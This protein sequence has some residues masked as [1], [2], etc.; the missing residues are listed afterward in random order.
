[1]VA[2][3]CPSLLSAR[4]SP[5]ATKNLRLDCF[6]KLSFLFACTCK[7][8]ACRTLKAPLQ[9]LHVGVKT[10]VKGLTPFKCGFCK[11]LAAFLKAALPSVARTVSRFKNARK[12]GKTSSVDLLD[13][14]LQ[15]SQC[16]MFL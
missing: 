10:L 8:F 7:V 15:G 16:M 1:M 2:L 5:P 14:D 4:L 9:N 3:I 6:T 12:V 11:F 13:K